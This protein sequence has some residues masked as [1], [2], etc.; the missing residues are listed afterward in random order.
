MS[1]SVDHDK[2]LATLKRIC[3]RER[4][5]RQA[6]EN[7]LQEKSR[8]LYESNK[9]L[10]T[11]TEHLQEEVEQQT[12]ELRDARDAALASAQAKSDFLA[13]MSHEI[14]TP[15]NG[16]LGMLYSLRKCDNDTQ[17]HTLIQ[18]AIHS[19]KLLIAVI[20]DILDFSKIESVGVNLENI[21]F[22]LRQTLEIAAHNFAA[23]ARGKGLD[24]VTH[25]HPA[26]PN[27]FCG[28]GYRIQQIVG[29]LISNAVKFTNVGQ[30]CVSASLIENGLIRIAVS[31]TGI[32]IAPE[33]LK[34]IFSAFSQA[35]TS[36]T[37]NFGG[38]GLGLSIC[39]K[40]TEAMGSQI[41]IESTQG[42]GSTFYFDIRLPIV[43]DSNLV[44][45]YGDKLKNY[46]FVMISQSETSVASC[47]EL[48]S[49]LSHHTF[50]S[51]DS[52]AAFRALTIDKTHP[53]VVFLDI[54]NLDMSEPSAMEEIK[55]FSEKTMVI[56][57]ENYEDVTPT[58]VNVDAHLLKPA[59]HRE[60]LNIIIDPN[61]LVTTKP[62]VQQ[63]ANQ[64]QIL[65]TRVL[66][67]DDNNINLD[68][69]TAILTD[70]GCKVRTCS[71]GQQAI[72]VLSKQAFDI[73]FMDIQMPEMDGLSATKAIRG[74]GQ[75]YEN[76]PIIA[77]TAHAQEEDRAK[78]LA[79]GMNEHVT[80]PIDPDALNTL[81]HHFMNKRTTPSTPGQTQVSQPPK[82]QTAHHPDLSFPGCDFDGALKKLGGK[83]DLLKSLII[84]FCDQ[85]GDADTKVSVLLAQNNVKD[86]LHITHT[87]KGSA[88]NL[89]MLAISES[90]AKVESQ[91]K[92]Q[93]MPT[94]ESLDLFY[95][96]IFELNRIK[97]HFSHL[98]NDDQEPDIVLDN[99]EINARLAALIEYI[100]DDIGQA[101]TDICEL[102]NATRGELKQ[103]LEA[104]KEKLY[105]FE[106]D[107]AK[108][109]I[110]KTMQVL[111]AVA[112]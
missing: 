3:A 31:D 72:D 83:F 101:Q 82:Q 110:T 61:R 89:G 15:L 85:F 27:A 86:A 102:V 96:Q 109:K 108:Q 13:N 41:Q 77:M 51:V 100:D 90:S 5:A 4:R 49:E 84:K 43:D 80:K 26:I 54:S 1:E 98:S 111:T 66:V 55:E 46:Q 48:F 104:I 37:R 53:L 76:L 88:S 40:I 9:K 67:V 19:G 94:D 78:H 44:S 74:L 99:S 28:D 20:N 45:F 95:Q 112:D 69:A 71:S 18:S 8:E 25:I 87:I 68:V 14:R 42:E 39:A 92:Q 32:G 16:V 17:R 7:L 11:L 22:D 50:Q 107:D 21:D 106:F 47:R 81:L 57:L 2:E 60:L 33:Q 34:N 24:I 105:D 6:A 58:P 62:L 79:A 56:S 23:T 93:Q 103:L 73:I 91:L 35:D 36:V 59:R 64:N 70:L 97:A 10:T 65:G 38:T 63:E 12:A 29:N 75:P 52:L 30:V